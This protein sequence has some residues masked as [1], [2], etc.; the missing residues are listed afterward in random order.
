MPIFDTY[1]MVDW[2]ATK[3]SEPAEKPRAEKPHK[4]AIWWA[5]RRANSGTAWSGR[6]DTQSVL[7]RMESGLF[8]EA[9]REDAM[10]H[11]ARF[12]QNEIKEDRRVLVGF[13]FAFGYPADF[14]KVLTKEASARSVWEWMHRHVLCKDTGRVVEADRF[15]V[16]ARI[17]ELI[18]ACYSVD[19][20]PFY[21][22]ERLPHLLGVDAYA[23][24]DKPPKAERRNQPYGK[25]WEFKFG[26]K[27]LTDRV[28]KGA[29]PVWKLSTQGAV[30]SQVLLGISWLHHL[31]EGIRTV[32][33]NES[34][35]VWPLS[36]S[37]LSADRKP[38]VVVVEIF[39]SILGKV[40]EQYRMGEIKDA[41]QVRLC[42]LAYSLLDRDGDLKDLFD[43]GTLIDRLSRD[44][45]RDAGLRKDIDSG[46]EAIENEEGWILGVGHE[47]ELHRV[48]HEYFA[49]EE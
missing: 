18:K 40:V 13:D 23:Y 6:K 21:G 5:A 49:D 10:R 44:E 19:F 31:C 1:V 38:K 37:T 39:P 20:G 26:Q 4:D 28:A 12:L 17:N 24:A 2:S 41:A 33:G 32:A 16:A 42:A 15:E 3:P 25:E 29:H 47:S 48:L 34:C 46:R 8:F 30:G 35:V 9:G 22:A 36:T 43:L 27:R 14:A 45:S 7:S 11:L